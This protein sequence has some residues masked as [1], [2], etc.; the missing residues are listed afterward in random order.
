[1]ET[2]L[3]EIKNELSEMRNQMVNMATKDDISKLATKEDVAD[4]PLI[5]QAVLEARQELAAVKE[6]T[7]EVKNDIHELRGN[8]VQFEEILMH[9]RKLI[10]LL[11]IKTSDH[12]AQLKW[13]R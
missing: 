7:D 6:T 3:Q 1:M 5:K 11:T 12:E 2:I 8:D 4:I 9:Q 13:V 10:D